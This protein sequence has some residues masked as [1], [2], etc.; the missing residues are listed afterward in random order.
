MKK[1]DRVELTCDLDYQPY[2]IARRG[3]RGTV[4][5]AHEFLDIRLDAHHAGLNLYENCIWLDNATGGPVV[6]IK[7][8]RRPMPAVLIMVAAGLAGLFVPSLWSWSQA[9]YAFTHLFTG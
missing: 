9:A 5:A 2:A 4:V 7:Q 3:E 1:G 8:L 6:G